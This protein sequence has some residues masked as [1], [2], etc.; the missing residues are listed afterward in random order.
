MKLCF[1]VPNPAHMRYFAPI[2]ELIRDVPDLEF[3]FYII[4]YGTKYC[5]LLIDKNYNRVKEIL[6][7]LLPNPQI[8]M[9]IDSASNF[10]WKG[11]KIECDVLFTVE[12]SYHNYFNFKKHISIQH[13]FDYIP[14]GKNKTSKTIYIAYNE[15]YGLDAQKRHN[16]DYVI[17]PIPTAFSNMQR[18]IDFARNQVNT[19]KKIAFIFYPIKGLKK[20]VKSMVKYLKLNDY[21]VIVKQRRK[22]Q[23]IPS[24][25]KADISTY[26]EIWYP[27]ESIFYPLISDVVIGFGTAAYFDLAEV[28]LIFID[29]ATIEYVRKGGAY[30]KPNLMN[31]FYFEKNF[32]KNTIKIIDQFAGTQKIKNVDL[33]II[34]NFYLNLIFD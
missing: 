7:E 25:I 33:K 2:I 6:S 22:H 26:D 34:K 29:N 27:S 32:Y 17:P 5:S 21:F 30:K 1:I 3:F 8:I 14:L 15:S 11:P 19:D 18:Q 31:F 23:D 12:F 9:L 28:G 10:E 4:K 24:N 20:L 16:I 13:G